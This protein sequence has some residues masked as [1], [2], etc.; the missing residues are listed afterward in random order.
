MWTLDDIDEEFPDERY[1]T[2]YRRMYRDLYHVRPRG[3]SWDDLESFFE[4]FDA[5]TE[6][7]Y[8]EDVEAE[9]VR[10]EVDWMSLDDLREHE[11]YEEVG[12]D[13]RMNPAE[14]WD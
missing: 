6:A 4:D 7:D 8:S 1:G 5:L 13:L 14:E 3:L 11:L 10:E 12:F 2:L 9:E